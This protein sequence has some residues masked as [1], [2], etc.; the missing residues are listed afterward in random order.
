MGYITSRLNDLYHEFRPMI[1]YVIAITSLLGIYS[2]AMAQQPAPQAIHSTNAPTGHVVSIRGTGFGSDATKLVVTFGA[3]RVMTTG[4]VSDQLLEVPAP[5]GAT[6]DNISVTNIMSGLTGYTPQNFLLSFGGDFGFNPANLGPQQD[7]ATEPGL[8]D[9]CLCDFNSDGLVDIATA[10]QNAATAG[11]L[12]NSSAIGTIAL[13]PSTRPLTAPPLHAK[14]GDLNGDGK[15]ELLF[16]E[17]GNG[18]RVFIMQNNTTGATISFSPTIL[19]L[20]LPP[21]QKTKQIQIGDLDLDGK[22][23]VIVTDIKLGTIN[24]FVNQSSGGALAFSPTVISTKI[25]PSTDGLIVKDLNGDER[26]EIATSKYAD[27]QSDLFILANKSTP[28]NISFDA[29]VTFAISGSVINLKAGDLDGDRKPDIVATQLLTNSVSVFRNTSTLTAISFAAPVSFATDDRP[30]GLDL[31]D[32]DGDGKADII[33]ASVFKKSITILNNISSP[34]SFSFQQH[35][36]TTNEVNRHINIG[37]LDGDGK[38][39]IVFTSIDNSNV[40]VF[41]NRTCMVPVIEPAGPLTICSGTPL[42]LNATA[43]PG[44]TYEWQ[45]NGAAQSNTPNAFFDV[46]AGGNYTVVAKQEGGACAKV[47]NSVSVGISGSGSGSASIDPISP[48]CRGSVLALKVTSTIPGTVTYKWTGPNNFTATGTSVSV[49]NFQSVNAG[50]YHVDVIVGTC[51]YQQLSVVADIVD[52]GNFAINYSNGTLICQGDT[53][54]LSVSSQAG[55]T[56]QWY[57]DGSMVGGATS[58]AYAAAATGNYTVKVKPPGCLEIETDPVSISVVTAPVAAFTFSPAVACANQLVAF[59]NQS[60]VDP[61]ATPVYQ[62]EFGDAQTSADKDPS[63][64]YTSAGGSPYAIKLTVSY[65]GCSDL[66]T[67][68]I[69]VTAAAPIQIINPNAAGVFKFC[70]G[71]SIEL[72]LAGTF[73]AYSWSTGETTPTAYAKGAGIFSVNAT[74]ADGCVLFDDQVVTMDPAPQ[75]EIKATPASI[76][77]GESAQLEAS[78]GLTGYNWTPDDGTLSAVNISNPTASPLVSTTY[79]VSA[80]SGAGCPGRGSIEVVVRGEPIVNKLK[81]GKFFS[82][83]DDDK[84]PTWLVDKIEEFSQCGVSIYDDKGVKVFEAKPYLNDW[85]G[86]FKGKKLPDGVYYYVIRCDGEEGKPRTG[87]I[88][89]LR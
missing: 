62:W 72:G 35:I 73:T 51:L 44:T 42:R 87:S 49:S 32:L 78:P 56:Y 31:G 5:P 19:S 22:P 45:L 13:A 75:I 86:T 85:D 66:K 29:F 64:Q 70:E 63:H 74:T 21:G 68:A 30:Y 67:D 2:S 48:A 81:P 43:S 25:A 38:P 84:N 50:R 41:R 8:F 15:P 6:F 4:N 52:L 17:G 60:A 33:A 20:S 71:D 9:Q 23:E 77:E 58:N 3:A 82:P 47:S 26:P 16:S 27:T 28:G 89:V 11:I 12:T 79:L 55:F 54:L 40:S 37:D 18:V 10:S 53:K 65:A 83:N 39:D 59:T 46:T 88:T 61:S 14:C 36:K 80:S 34:G 1:R 7:F 76:N 69:T 57:K 24:I